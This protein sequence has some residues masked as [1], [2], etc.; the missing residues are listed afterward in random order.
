VF[1]CCGR[2][3]AARVKFPVD[4]SGITQ[5]CALLWSKKCYEGRLRSESNKT[6]TNRG[7]ANT[8]WFPLKGKETVTPDQ[9]IER[10]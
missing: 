9:R 5:I 8:R 10:A 6:R 1:Y 2:D 4:K 3:S 7:R